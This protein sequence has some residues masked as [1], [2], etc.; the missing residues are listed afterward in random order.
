MTLMCMAKYP[1]LFRVGAA[2]A[3]VVNWQLYDTHYTERY[4]GLL[5]DN[6]ENY[7]LSNVTTYAKNLDGEL[8]IIH[9]MIDENVHFTHSAELIQSLIE[10]DKSYDL[11][12]FPKERH[13]PRGHSDRVYM[14]KRMMDFLISKI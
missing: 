4:L 13:M 5:E 1:E 9:G 10:N 14:E 7:D 8:M 11:L 12:A 6:Y 3:P 2:G